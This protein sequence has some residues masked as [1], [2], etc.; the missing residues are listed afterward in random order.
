MELHESVAEL[1]RGFEESSR[2][3]TAIGD[4]TRQHLIL[5][6]LKI[7]D[8]R[9]VRVCDMTKT[10][11]LSRPAVSHHLQ[12]MKNAGIVKSRKEGTKVYYYFDPGTEAFKKLVSTLNLAMEISKELPDRRGEE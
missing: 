12:I 9:G 7:G 3:L 5:E 8:C 1:A 10:T 6:M 4:E 11:N 2:M